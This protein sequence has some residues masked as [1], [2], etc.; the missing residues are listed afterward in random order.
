[1]RKR[2]QISL[3]PFIRIATFLVVFTSIACIH[4]NASA[5]VKDT[6]EPELVVIGNKEG[7]P[8]EIS[9]EELVKIMKA[10]RPRW[11]N[12]TKVKIALM[13]PKTKIGSL[14]AKKIYGMSSQELSKYWVA[15][16]FEGRASAPEF[17]SDEN[18]LIKY[19]NKTEGAIGIIS[20]I[21]P[22]VKVILISGGKFDNF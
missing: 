15:V 3:S 7:T 6:E 10:Q 4:K 1:M 19:V 2:L 17:F 21:E 14:T 20:Q 16:V 9:W 22:S 8:N 11:V 13:K 12:G 5:Q 18:D